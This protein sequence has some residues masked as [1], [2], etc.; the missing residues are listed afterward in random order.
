MFVKA[1]AI[2]LDEYLSAQATLRS[3]Q[4]AHDEFMTASGFDALLTP[5]APGEAPAIETT[6]DSVFNRVWTSLG[7]PTVHLPVTSGPSGLPLGIQLVG[8]RWSDQRLLTSAGLA[9]SSFGHAL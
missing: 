7:V 3:A 4:E 1:E 2:G 5:S 8:Q 9:E 6:G